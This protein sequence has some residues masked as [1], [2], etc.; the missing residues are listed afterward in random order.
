MIGRGFFVLITEAFRVDRLLQVLIQLVR[1][2]ASLVMFSK[3][4]VEIC[5]FSTF[6]CVFFFR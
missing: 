5:W 2:T 4:R 6:R 3:I 1:I